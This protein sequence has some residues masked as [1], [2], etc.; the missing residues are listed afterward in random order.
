M[1]YFRKSGLFSSSTN[2]AD[3]EDDNE[4]DDGHLETP[5]LKIEDCSNNRQLIFIR[6][7]SIMRW[8][9]S[10]LKVCGQVKE[11]HYNMR[12]TNGLQWETKHFI[13]SRYFTPLSPTNIQS[14]LMQLLDW[15]WLTGTLTPLTTEYNHSHWKFS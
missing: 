10:G 7:Q 3:L 9:I 13:T 4:G 2:I 1:K 6:H 5:T 14:C 15:F 8:L 11:L 12:T